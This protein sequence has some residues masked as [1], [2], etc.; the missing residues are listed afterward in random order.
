MT[1]FSGLSAFPITPA[2]HS[3]EIDAGALRRLVSRLA[4]AGVD[5]IGLLGSTGSYAYLSREERCRAL[6]AAVDEVRG[7]AP[8]IAG[9]GALRTDEAIRL[10]MDAKALG[11]DAGLLSAMSY[12]PLSQ[13][14][15]YEHFVAVADQSGLPLVIY[16]NPGTTHFQFSTELIARLSRHAGI[17]A[18]KYPTSSREAIPAHLEEQR[19]ALGVEF[20]LGYSG[21]WCCAEAMIAGAD[22]WYSVLGGILPVPC[23][24]IVRAAQQSDVAEARRLDA[25]LQPVWDLFRKHTSFRVVH[26]MARQLDLSDADPQRPVLPVCDKAKQDIRSVLAALPPEFLV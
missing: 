19:A 7:R 21:D 10:A 20:P 9:V 8:I 5:S 22:I 23:L 3:G 1:I 2:S 18:V 24:Q 11:A 25:A 15:V 17:V 12:L 14:E 4:A 6:E 13:N 26:E 16:D